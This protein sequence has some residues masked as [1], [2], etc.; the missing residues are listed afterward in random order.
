MFTSVRDAKVDGVF[1][2]RV[3]VCIIKRGRS[4]NA[5][6]EGASAAVDER[7]RITVVK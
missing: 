3:R 7:F 6:N 4:E 2:C 5:V 1:V